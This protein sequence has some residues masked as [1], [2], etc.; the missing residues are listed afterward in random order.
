MLIFQ[1]LSFASASN[2]WLTIYDADVGIY[3]IYVCVYTWINTLCVY[4]N[5]CICERIKYS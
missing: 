4:V 5:A 3:V 2:T 1:K